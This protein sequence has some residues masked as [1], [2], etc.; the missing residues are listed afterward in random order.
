MSRLSTI[1][2]HGEL[3]KRFQPS[4]K[5]DVRSPQEALHALTIMIPGFG[6]ALA[7]GEFHCIIGGDTETGRKLS[8]ANQLCYPWYGENRDFHLV[9]AIAGSG[10][11]SATKIIVGIAIVAIAIAAPYIGGALGGTMPETFGAAMGASAFGISSVSWGMVA[12]MGAVIALGGLAQAISPQPASSAQNQNSWLF[13]SMEN[14][15]TEGSPIPYVYGE[16]MVGSVVINEGILAYN[17]PVGT[18]LAAGSLNS[19]LGTGKG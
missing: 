17:I 19:I 5:L 6:D 12:F 7:T 16:F 13:N 3:G 10:H 2:L 14:T 18:T 15:Q 1:H 9:P 8:R 11:G 4:Y